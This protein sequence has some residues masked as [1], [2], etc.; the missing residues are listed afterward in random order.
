QGSFPN[1]PVFN[2]DGTRIV[3]SNGW[4]FLGKGVD[5]TARIWDLTSGRLV[6]TVPDQPNR[7][8]GSTFSPDGHM[9][10]TLAAEPIARLWDADSGAARATLDHGADIVTTGFSPDGRSVVTAGSDGRALLWDVTAAPP[11][12][13]L[14]L[15]HEE[16]VTDASFSPD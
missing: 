1:N 16:A 6:A 14:T 9:V 5:F 10:L 13:R 15:K 8:R 7:I 2:S 4:S 3:T 11:K 12:V